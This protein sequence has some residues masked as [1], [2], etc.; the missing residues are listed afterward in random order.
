MHGHGIG[1]RRQYSSVRWYV[2]EDPIL[3]DDKLIFAEEGRCSSLQ[4]QRNDWL[5]CFS[6]FFG[7]FNIISQRSQSKL[8]G[9]GYQ[10]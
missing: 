7:I 5:S 3:A 1:S 2:G 4:L 9:D 8:S 6:N 10:V